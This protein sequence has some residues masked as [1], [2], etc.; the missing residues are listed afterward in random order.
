[1]ASH[2]I[3]PAA[4]GQLRHDLDT[5]SWGVYL[6]IGQVQDDAWLAA[7]A[8]IGAM[9]RSEAYLITNSDDANEW[10]NDPNASGWPVG[11]DWGGGGPTGVCFGFGATPRIYLTREQAE[12]VL[13]VSAAY[14][15]ALELTQ[16]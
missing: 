3:P 10:K 11:S 16:A 5:P 2:T 4:L 15:K 7:K 6:V 12:D 14:V 1:M 9:A 8:V 13:I